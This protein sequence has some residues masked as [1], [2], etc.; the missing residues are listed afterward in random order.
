[1]STSRDCPRPSPASAWRGAGTAARQSCRAAPGTRPATCSRPASSSWPNA[2][3]PPG[4]PRCAPSRA[5]TST[6]SRAGRSI[7]RVR[8]AMSTRDLAIA[9]CM[10]A[11]AAGA[12]A[13]HAETP[14]LGRPISQADL[15]GWDINILPD[16]QNLPPGNGRAAD[17]A[18]I[19]AEKCAL[20]QGENGRGGR[21]ARLIGGP[22]KAS[23]DGGKTIANYWPYATTLFDLIRRAMPFTQPRSLTDDEVYALTAYLLAENKLIGENEEINAATL[24]KVRMPNRDNFVVQFPDRI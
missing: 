15:A 12:C 13:A 6:P 4:R 2:D 23:L 18:Q 17:G 19:Y 21:A 14:H 1:R 16:G 10:L 9:A 7:A 3:R 8:C 24:P 11:L 22:P 20:C 5:T